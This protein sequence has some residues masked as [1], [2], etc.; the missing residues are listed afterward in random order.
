MDFHCKFQEEI[1]KWATL[2]G[3]S[4]EQFVMQVM[5]ERLTLIKQQKSNDAIV[6]NI[7]E[8]LL[9]DRSRLH[10]KKGVLV[11]QTEPLTGFDVNAFVSDMRE[12]RIENPTRQ[13]SL[14]FCSIG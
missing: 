13:V 14:G 6:L 10:R 1:E 7:T 5:S 2:A 12:E 11:I 3:L 4:A 9:S 8:P